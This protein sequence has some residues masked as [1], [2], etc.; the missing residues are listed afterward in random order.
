MKKR[1]IALIVL[2][3]LLP[4]I[5]LSWAAVRI[6]RNDQVAI[7]QS[8]RELVE[9]RLQDVNQ[10]L[11]RTLET[12]SREM[13]DLLR[14]DDIDV[15]RLRL[16]TRN[17]PRVAQLFAISQRGELLYPRPTQVLNVNE[18]NFLLSAS[19]MF[20]TQALLDAVNQLEVPIDSNSALS[21]PPDQFRESSGWFGWYW[22]GGLQLIF[23][24][25]RPNGIIVGAA[26]ERARWM[27]DL[28]TEL[29]DTTGYLETDLKGRSTSSVSTGDTQFRLTNG[30]SETIYQWGIYAPTIGAL[31]LCE[32]PVV[33]PLQSWR[34]QAFVAP[35][36]VGAGNGKRWA[37]WAGF[38]LAIGLGLTAMA[39]VLYRDYQKTIN[40]A[41]QQVTFV[42][43]V[44]HELKTPL[45]NIQLYAE[46]LQK[47]LSVLSTED[48]ERPLAR[49]DV[50]ISETQRLGRLIN[51]VL[52]H[53]RKKRGTLHPIL[54]SRVPDEL[55]QSI[56]QRFIPSLEAVEIEVDL[57][58]GA[59]RLQRFDSD[60]LEQVLGNL[61]SNVE[62]YAACGKLLR[63][64]SSQSEKELVVLV[65]DR[66]P[67]IDSHRR[68]EVFRPFT[69]LTNQISSSSGTGI[70]LSIAR[71]LCRLHGGDLQLESTEKGCRFRIHLA[72]E[73]GQQRSPK[74]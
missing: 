20:T 12:T 1:P 40:E 62:K 67:G 21:K 14:I 48:S 15:E 17:Q 33:S 29:P 7:Q 18:R 43:Q 73:I 61:I 66:G 19:K 45:T 30:A 49:V 52:S 13:Q 60:F 38:L 36:I 9:G 51:N 68:A 37:T 23:W 34:L 59:N 35:Q 41:R 4:M 28:I 54:R 55:I 32:V 16:M 64:E 39:W 10:N 44:S 26:L 3:V 69:R 22:D 27:A 50:V 2:I 53:A 72:C 42:N 65:E 47:D 63:I 6:D 11:R 5:L 57:K 25:R 46:L 24:Q 58:L 56:I 74:T 31:P 71:E 8:Y 70:G